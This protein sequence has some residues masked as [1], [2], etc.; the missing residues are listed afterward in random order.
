MPQEPQTSEKPFVFFK[1]D[2]TFCALV[3]PKT[4]KMVPLDTGKEWR[5]MPHYKEET[6]TF[7]YVL[8]TAAMDCKLRWAHVMLNGRK[9]VNIDQTDDNAPVLAE[10]ASRTLIAQRW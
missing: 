4:S 6:E 10:V 9:A 1:E 7:E 8:D 2:G 3:C 5:L